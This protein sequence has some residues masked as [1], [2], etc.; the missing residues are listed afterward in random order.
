MVFNATFNNIQ[1]YHIREDKKDKYLGLKSDPP[2]YL[3]ILNAEMS[4]RGYYRC[5]IEYSTSIIGTEKKINGR[6]VIP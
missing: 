4:D 1:L 3:W 2:Y 5:C 6:R